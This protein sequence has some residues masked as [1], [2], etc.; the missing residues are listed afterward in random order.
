MLR[1][2]ITLQIFD[3]VPPRWILSHAAGG[4]HERDQRNRHSTPHRADLRRRA[5]PS[6]FLHTSIVGR[7]AAAFE[8]SV[9][10]SVL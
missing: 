2:E 9:R 6:G 3:V 5:A 10:P 8:Y 4:H 1:L 7:S